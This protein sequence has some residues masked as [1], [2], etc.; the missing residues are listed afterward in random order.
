VITVC[1]NARESC[2]L[3]PSRT[4]VAHWSMPDPAEAQGTDDQKR[5]AFRDAFRLIRRRIDLMLAIPLEKLEQA[6]REAQLR[7]IPKQAP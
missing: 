3:F 6:A 4:A 5:E 1:D 7:A 2:P